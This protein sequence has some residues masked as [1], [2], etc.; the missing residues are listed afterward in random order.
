MKRIGLALLVVLL[1]GP[2][3][4]QTPT[5]SPSGGW[6]VLSVDDYRALR[7][8]AYPPGLPPE[9][10]PVNAAIS[11]I[12]YDLTVTGE[13]AAGQARLVVDVFKDGWVSVPI[14]R[15]LRIKDARL[16]GR[17]VTLVDGPDKGQAGPS[18]LLS[19]VGRFTIALDLVVPITSRAGTESFTLPPAPSPVQRLALTL[20]SAD[21]SLN[22]TGG[23]VAERGGPFLLCG[24]VNEPLVVSWS[25]RREV[26]AA[27]QPVRFRG[28][29]TELV[30][31]GE[32]SA[33][34]AAQVIVEVLQG[35]ADRVTL[36]LPQGFV[37][38][39]VFGPTV[40]DW[41]VRGSDLVVSLIEPAEQTV[42][43]RIGGETRV[44]RDGR[45]AVP[46][47]RLSGA[48]RETGGVAVEVLG[49]GEIK[50]QAPNGLDP[51]DA[52]D[53]GQMMA[54]RQ[55]PAL[56]A[57]RS[58][59][60][61]PDAPRSLDVTIARYTPQAVL[62]AN[63]EEARF[64]TLMTEDGK[65]LVEGAWAVRNTQRSFVAIT[66]PAGTTLWSAS[67]DGRPVRPGQGPE[68]T[69]LLPILKDHGDARTASVVRVL[70]VGRG[71]AWS[72]EGTALLPLASVD[73]PVSRTGLQLYHSPRY[74]MEVEPGAFHEQTYQPPASAA[75]R[76][77][78]GI[79]GGRGGG[80]GTGW[81]EGGIAGGV[82]GGVVGGV[83]AAAGGGA[84]GKDERADVEMRNLVEE[85]QR[86][87]R[88]GTI[89]GVLPIA[90]PFPAVGPSIYLASELTPEGKAP[91]AKFTF[92]R[93]VK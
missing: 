59:P 87:T 13:S 3:F 48:E 19:R 16:D 78:A 27:S 18:V 2:A 26:R 70:Y 25:R 71:S 32:D 23:F 58:R 6:V 55:S 45:I 80:A 90:M 38:N 29:V 12:D 30:G 10:P 74:R 82:A 33:Q 40:G 47:L 62:T 22:V 66:L 28:S 61:A 44:A 91:E 31:L 85:F 77:T 36:R 51:A 84:Y 53:L 37:T 68:G 4:A 67:I 20:R 21:V 60:Q 14:P 1:A 7:D 52:A 81:V 35:L 15:G 43:I 56:V 49:A 75:L 86:T 88:A 41:E 93:E 92:K 50:E 39:Q 72:S 64:T 17:P 11:R 79:G 42:D 8:K 54:G 9:P 73:L 5:P 83:P 34:V 24:R 89:A 63:V 65:T 46:L 69:L 57:F 76:Q